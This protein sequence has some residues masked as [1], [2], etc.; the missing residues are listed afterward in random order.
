M[1]ALRDG[2]SPPEQARLSARVRDRVLAL[3]EVRSAGT[4]LVFYAF[5]SEVRTEGIIGAVVGRGGRVLLPVVEGHRL[6]A[7]PY[8]PGDPLRPG[9]SGISEPPGPDGIP[10][11]EVDVVIAPGLAFDREGNRLGYGRGY[12]DRFLATVRP[13][14]ARI[15]VGFHVQL[16]DRVPHGPADQPLSLVVTDVET[17]VC[18]PAPGAS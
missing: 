14:A 5:G 3:E 9:S 4:V 10:A 17:V 8:R 6:R 1:R 2:I 18:R 11:Q 15:G 16:V 7:A 13:D 12:F